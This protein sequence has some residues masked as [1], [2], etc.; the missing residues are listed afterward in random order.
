MRVA[1]C[2]DEKVYRDAITE[3]LKPFK[4]IN[5][6]II[7]DEFCCGENLL[8]AYEQG[9]R[10]D[11]IFLDVE[12]KELSGVDT[13]QKIRVLDTTVILIFI[14]S[15][16]KYVPEAFIVNAFQFLVKPVGKEVFNKEFERALTTY[17]KMKYKYQ[18]MVKGK[19]IILEVKDI[20]YIETFGRRLRAVTNTNI[21]EFNGSISA[22]EKKLAGY[23][24]ARCHK[25]VLVNMHY[26]F[27]SENNSFVLLNEQTV[28]ISKHYKNEALSKLNKFISGC[29][30]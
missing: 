28:P 25:G 2:D 6:E 12:M 4:E 5:P 14:T 9:E 29:S 3:H 11:L 10:F 23:G 21:Y 27:R 30:I 8:A 16:T 22:E 17:K 26:I 7:V 15:H 18:I 13:A 24:F 20:L 19:P 1:V